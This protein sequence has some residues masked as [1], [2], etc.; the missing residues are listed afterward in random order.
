LIPCCWTMRFF[1]PI[2]TLSCHLCVCCVELNHPFLMYKSFSLR[3]KHSQR[4]IRKKSGKIQAPRKLPPSSLW[5]CVKT[6]PAIG[7]SSWS[8]LLVKDMEE[9]SPIPLNLRIS[10]KIFYFSNL[11]KPWLS[12][13]PYCHHRH[14]PINVLDCSGPLQ[15]PLSPW[16]S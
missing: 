13:Y 2:P 16:F 9:T 4:N 3:A 8:T 5:H 14:L 11:N 7:N 15:A 1:L 10:V 6:L 12:G